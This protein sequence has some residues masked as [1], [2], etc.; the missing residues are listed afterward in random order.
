[1]VNGSPPLQSFSSLIYSPLHPPATA[2]PSFL[3]SLEMEHNKKTQA[4]Y[5]SQNGV[6]SSQFLSVFQH[7]CV[8]AVTEQ[9][10]NQ[11]LVALTPAVTR[12]F[13]QNGHTVYFQTG[14]ANR[15]GFTDQQYKQAGAHQLNSAEEVYKKCNIIVK[16]NPPQE[17]EFNYVQPQQV[18][19]CMLTATTTSQQ[20]QQQFLQAMNERKAT[21]INYNTLMNTTTTTTTT[22]TTGSNFPVHNAM[23]EVKGYLGVQQ[24]MNL[25]GATTNGTLF[26]QVAGIPG[27]NVLILGAGACGTR[28]AT[29]A[30]ATGAQVTVMDTN[31][32]ALRHI[33]QTLPNVQ[34]MQYT[35]QNLE[36]TLPTTNTL[37]GCVVPTYTR[38]PTLVTD[39]QLQMMQQGSIAID[40]AACAGGNFQATNPTTIQKPTYNWN[41]I[42]MYTAANIA[43]LAPQTTSSAFSQAAMPYLLQVANKGWKRA[44]IEFYGLQEGVAT[45]EG[46]VT[47]NQLANNTQ[48]KYTPIEQVLENEIQQIGNTQQQ[49]NIVNLKQQL[50]TFRSQQTSAFTISA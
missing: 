47:N 19:F 9:D 39:N 17:S 15:A 25:T 22:N 24:A 38:A 7:T 41:G 3:S 48:Y 46:C 2:F 33:S 12:E 14:F 31:T 36:Q 50:N 29:L 32:E 37:I 35:Q 11:Y 43:C 40:L 49:Q 26:G 20:Q 5:T 23:C 10:N 16:V 30:A 18:I 44:V 21:V 1:M 28:A 13:V 45:A 4:T 6:Y 8:G 42:T 34:T 27:A